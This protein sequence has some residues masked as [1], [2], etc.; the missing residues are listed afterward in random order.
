MQY[1]LIGYV[2]GAIDP[3]E[4]SIIE[5]A[6]KTDPSVRHELRR[7]RET[8]APLDQIA[9]PD[10]GPPARLIAQTIDAINRERPSSAGLPSATSLR[11][12]RTK[13]LT[14]PSIGR[15]SV[16]NLRWSDYAALSIAA[17][18]LLALLIPGLV[19]LRQTARRTA[20]VNNLQ[21]IGN[22]LLRFV[23][24]DPA[25]RL[26]AI[27]PS[28][29][30]AFAG[31]YS[32]RLSDAGLLPETSV[33]FCANRQDVG[34][35]PIRFVGNSSLPSLDEIRRADVNRLHAIQRS[36]GG[37]YA[38]TLGVRRGDHYGPPKYESRTSFAV[39][40]DQVTT[41]MT[42]R[43]FDRQPHGG[44]MNVLYE[45]GSVKFVSFQTMDSLPDHPLQ[46][47]DGRPEAGLTIDDASLAPSWRAPFVN[48]QQR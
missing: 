10:Q 16:N 2:T 40:S 48:A 17:A 45:D 38:Y 25:G 18:M 13:T 11:P 29:P 4:R 27:T 14:P 41:T 22:S 39:L 19:R 34:D 1:D 6:V 28:G 35:E 20:C 5:E 32:I 3:H 7:L 23:D 47:H 8:I 9:I 24:R 43:R 31:I 46:N 37:D 44:G 30:E 36:A 33:R 12:R 21:Q 26:P 15:I 42:D